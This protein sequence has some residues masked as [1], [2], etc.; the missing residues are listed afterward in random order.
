MQTYK[1]LLLLLKDLL[2]LVRP[3]AFPMMGAV[4]FGALGHI[5]ATAIPSL[6]SYWLLTGEF[7]VKTGLITFGILALCRSLFRYFEQLLNHFV[8][9]RTLAIIRDKVFRK[10]RDLA[11]AKMEE[12]NKKL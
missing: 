4:F 11:P 2:F 3:L 5:L 7:N 6:G 10:L 8:A 12:K 9:F 1:K